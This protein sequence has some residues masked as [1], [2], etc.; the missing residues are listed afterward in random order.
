M[1]KSKDIPCTSCIHAGICRH[2]ED[3]IKV[4]RAINN[5]RIPIS[6]SKNVEMYCKDLDFLQ[7]IKP[8]CKNY[9]VPTAYGKPFRK[10]KIYDEEESKYSG[11]MGLG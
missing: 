7:T 1:L 2:R 5:L 11:F 10:K 8:I 9:N 4:V 6:S 3:F